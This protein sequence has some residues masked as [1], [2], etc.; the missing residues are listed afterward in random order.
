MKQGKKEKASVATPQLNDATTIVDQTEGQNFVD[1]IRDPVRMHIDLTIMNE[2]TF[3]FAKEYFENVFKQDAIFW[4]DKNEPKILRAID[5]GYKLD[6]YIRL[7][8]T[9]LRLIGYPAC[10]EINF[11][12]LF[13]GTHTVLNFYS[14]YALAAT[15][16]SIPKRKYW[17]HGT[18]HREA[19]HSMTEQAIKEHEE[20]IGTYP[21]FLKQAQTK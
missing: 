21:I 8:E 6:Y 17:N 1:K 11:Y 13:P 14:F 4:Y 20:R 18:Y 10:E 7:F 12:V 5:N 2:K 3:P 15:L 9:F 19:D 16:V